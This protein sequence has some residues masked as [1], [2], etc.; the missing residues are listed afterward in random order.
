MPS[1]DLEFILNYLNLPF[2]TFNSI[3]ARRDYVLIGT[4]CNPININNPYGNC[5]TK[6][7]G[8]CIT[9]SSSVLQRL[10]KALTGVGL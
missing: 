3:K 10:L 8:N 1:P 9:K 5:I 7:Y 4:T 6:S 2:S